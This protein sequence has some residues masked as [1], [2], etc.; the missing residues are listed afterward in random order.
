MSMLYMY[1]D[2]AITLHHG[3]GFS[4]YP[5]GYI[6]AQI[7]SPTGPFGPNGHNGTTWA[8]WVPCPTGPNRPNWAQQ[9]KWAQR[10]RR[11]GLTWEFTLIAIGDRFVHAPQKTVQ[12]QP[13][14]KI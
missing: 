2:F 7:L 8:Q 3:N 12:K 1:E 11:R 13:S 6:C 14:P 9:A 10:G 4:I 5:T